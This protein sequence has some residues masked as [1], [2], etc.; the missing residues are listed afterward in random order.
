[1]GRGVAFGFG[2]VAAVTALAVGKNTYFGMITV[3]CRLTEISAI[4]YTV[5]AEPVE[6]F[7]RLYT[8]LLSR[9]NFTTRITMTSKVKSQAAK[10]IVHDVELGS[11]NVFADL[12]HKSKR[13][14]YPNQHAHST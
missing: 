8:S 7:I 2:C 13:K 9:Q 14:I 11:G 1:M 5:R 6:A 3:Q 4:R 12:N 10:A